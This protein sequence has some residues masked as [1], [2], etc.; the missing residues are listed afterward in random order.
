MDQKKRPVLVVVSLN[1]STRERVIRD[2]QT[3]RDTLRSLHGATPATAFAATDKSIGGWLI[4]SS[5][6]LQALRAAIESPGNPLRGHRVPPPLS[7]SD[8]LFLI[9]ASSGVSS[10]R[11]LGGT[12]KR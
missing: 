7:H 1:P 12:P 4:E 3:I 6:P 11:R 8:E 2:V 9:D 10:S 5:L